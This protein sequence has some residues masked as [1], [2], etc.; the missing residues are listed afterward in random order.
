MVVIGVGGVFIFFMGWGAPSVRRGAGSVVEVGPYRYGPREFDRERASRIEQYRQAMG[1]QFDPDAIADTLDQITTEALI[2]RSVLALE[3]EDLG[4]RVGKRE[5]E[6]DVLASSAFR[7]E[8]GRFDRQAF[9][10]WAEYEYGNQRNFMTD[11]RTA[12]LAAKLVRL[13]GELAYVSEGE[14]RQAIEQR[15]EEVQIAFVKLDAAT[16]P[17]DREIS[18]AE[19]AELIAA[20]ED[21]LR[22]AYEAQAQRFDRPE[23]VR[24]RHILLRA[25]ASLPAPERAAVRKRAEALLERLHGG[26]NFPE[27]AEQL[28]EDPG[29]K[30]RGGDLGF[31]GRG[32]MVKAFEDV[33]FSLEPGKLS[34]VVETAY[35]F[36]VIRSEEYRPAEHQDYEQ[37]RELLARERIGRDAALA[38]AREAAEALAEAVRSGRS[39]EEAARAR[40]L[41]LSRSGWLRRRPDGFVPE[42]GAAQE[43]L[44]AAF[45][46]AP[47]ESSPRIF[48]VGDQLAMVQVLARQRPEPSPEEVERERQALFERER[49]GQI[50]AWLSAR[51]AQLLAEGRIAVD[52]EA[53]GY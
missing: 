38:R 2:Q 34:D 23:Q 6:Q 45:T 30:Q 11:Q 7:D 40:G 20:H 24:A 28:S 43:L 50:V 3:A 37:V 17:A 12:M 18:D 1:E 31:F 14:A 19:V 42:L 52:L 51:R 47:G 33:A 39:L 16:P 49:E 29:S 8:G 4:L 48:E 44:A 15:T 10:S 26:A 46:L 5:I 35:G 9:A 13:V 25:D 22:A 53:R 41:T 27:L 36:H 21:D 32:Q